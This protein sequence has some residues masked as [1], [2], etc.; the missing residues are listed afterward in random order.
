MSYVR[1]ATICDQCGDRGAEYCA[2][3]LTCDGCGDDV[4]EACASIYGPDPPGHAVCHGCADQV[5]AEDRA[6]R[7][8]IDR[9]LTP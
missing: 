2:H 4:C 6:E 3:T 1:F 7:Q 5:T 9:W 8:S